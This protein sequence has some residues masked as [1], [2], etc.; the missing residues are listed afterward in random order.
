[1]TTKKARERTHDMSRMRG[2]VVSLIARVARER[3]SHAEMLDMR[4]SDV[5]NRPEWARL[6]GT[7]QQELLGMIRGAEQAWHFCDAIVWTHTVKGQVYIAP[8]PTDLE[9]S[10]IESSAHRWA[11]DLTRVWFGDS[12]AMEPYAR[13]EAADAADA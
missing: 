1:M 8:L 12:N 5:F 10:E 9:Y 7:S 4:Q 6:T 11:A 2:A 3:L 13:L